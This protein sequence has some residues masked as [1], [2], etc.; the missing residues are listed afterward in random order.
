[1]RLVPTRS[2]GRYEVK[3][4]IGRGGMGAVLLGRDPDLNRHLALKVLQEE[5]RDRPERVKRFVE[6]AQI[7]AQLQHPGVVPVH[8]LGRDGEANPFLAMKLVKGRTLAALLAER[9]EP[10]RDLPHFLAIFEQVCQALAYAHARRVIHRDLKPAN[11]M[12]GKFGEVQVMDWGLAKVLVPAPGRA[13]TAAAV[14]EI[15]TMRAAGAGPESH[16]GMG[17]P[18]YMPPEQ[19]NG[20]T[21]RV[22]ERADVFGLGAVLCEVLT[23]LPPYHGSNRDEVRRM[24]LRGDVAAALARLDVCGADAELAALAKECLAPEVDRRPRDAGVVAQRVTAYRAGVQEKLRAAERERA[25]AQAREEEARATAHAERKARRRTAG[26]AAALLVLGLGGSWLFWQR[27]ER[28]R[29]AGAD[30]DR[31]EDRLRQDKVAEAEAALGQAEARLAGADPE[32]LRVRAQGI[33]KDLEMLRKLDDAGLQVAE[34]RDGVWGWKAANHTYAEAFRWY[35]LEVMDE[36]AVPSV[37]DS[38]IAA[39]LVIALDHWGAIL[40]HE[41]MPG[42]E[43]RFAITDQIDGDPRRRE[44]RTAAGRKELLR[45]EAGWKELEELADRSAASLTPGTTLLLGRLL[46]RAGRPHKAV[47]VFRDAQRY[48][49]ANV[50]ICNAVGVALAQRPYYRFREAVGFCRA[51]L[52]LNPDSFILQNNVAFVLL[53]AKADPREAEVACRRAIKLAGDR[54]RDL[55]VASMNLSAALQDQEGRAV[56]ATEA[57]RQAIH[58]Q[59]DLAGAYLNLGNALMDQGR[60]DAAA[61]AYDEAVARAPDNPGIHNSIGYLFDEEGRLPEA[62]AAYR[63]ALELEPDNT[64]ALSNLG[65]ALRRQG[66]LPQ[67]VAALRMAVALRPDLPGP[68]TNLGLALAKSDQATEAEYHLRRAVELDPKS[69]NAYRALGELLPDLGRREEAET[70]LRKALELAPEEASAHDSLGIVLEDLGRLE[71]AEA[72]HRRALELDAANAG[73]H[74]N[75]GG[76]LAT[77]GRL[78]EA[79]AAHRQALLL[80]PNN[81]ITR[82]NL[83]YALGEQGR[84]EEA[85]AACRT[86]LQRNPEHAPAYGNLAFVLLRQGRADQALAASRRAVALQP[87]LALAHLNLAAALLNLGNAPEALASCREALRLA[88]NRAQFHFLHGQVL[89]KLGDSAGAVRAYRKALSLQPNFADACEALGRAMLEMEQLQEAGELIQR[90]LR[91]R[92]ES[93]ASHEAYG[94]LLWHQNEKAK[95]EAAFRRVIDLQP[96]LAMGYNNL[97]AV[98][99]AL[100][101]PKEAESAA[102]QALLFQPDLV[103]AWGNLGAALRAQD[104]LTEAVAVYRNAL[105]LI[106]EDARI[107]NVLGNTLL[108]QRQWADAVAAFRT[109]LARKP[110]SAETQSNLAFAL[111]ELGRLS[112]AVTACRAALAL[113]P[114]HAPAYDNLASA[115]LAQGKLDEAEV[116]CRKAIRLAK[117]EGTHRVTLG[118]VLIQQGK[119]PEALKSY[120]LAISLKPVGLSPDT[121]VKRLVRE[122]KRLI[123]LEAKLQAILDGKVK[124]GGAERMELARLCSYKRQYTDA[125]RFYAEAFKAQPALTDSR[126]SMHRYH[127]ARAAAQGNAAGRRQALDWLRAELAAWGAWAKESPEAARPALQSALEQWTTDPAFAGVRD[128]KALG[129]LPEEE[130]RDWRKLWEQ[131]EALAGKGP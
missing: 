83:S 59:P 33:K 92:P 37:R 40:Y 100:S 15:E 72:A 86:A 70:V 125:V 2:L 124:V 105:E 58:F 71:E 115:L 67:A 57:A 97:S 130:Q 89:A 22:D 74:D 28:L 6:E 112:E 24:A 19:A 10:S 131:V 77:Q 127:A 90:L 3:G 75:L 82:T 42:W 104:R 51:A 49:P 93:A 109:S 34:W 113:Q 118:E 25:A 9:A 123:E 55:A 27:G 26:L 65:N 94:M 14:S 62:I 102:R 110:E 91:L 30:L 44:I 7:G 122:A 88:P 32:S 68:H 76:V 79:E 47:A 5:H 12:V 116:A 64:D 107:W 119:F 87:G 114:G 4:E 73:F 106:P 16:G 41:G 126:R 39:R 21:A 11:V 85:E 45:D 60:F 78:K 23:G 66:Q 46:E 111:G 50:F 84:L 96:D 69:P 17:T 120:D 53:L 52:A 98:L 29:A 43:G 108:E 35:G 38:R 80:D 63:W 99:L 8:E 20:E 18:A 1:V 101:R 129:R 117:D 121:D 54:P 81:V 103:L 31:A 13:E 56:E 61:R 128:R 48:H 95:A 36:S